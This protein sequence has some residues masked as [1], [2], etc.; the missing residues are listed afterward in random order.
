[1]AALLVK[2]KKGDS[3]DLYNRYRSDRTVFN[4]LLA[5][6]A[7]NNI[8]TL[9]D[10]FVDRDTARRGEAKTGGKTHRR[11]LDRAAGKFDVLA[12]ML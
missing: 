12:G 1:L 8:S 9:E 11:D 6:K 7:A 3:H 2:Y 5:I 10:N 4:W